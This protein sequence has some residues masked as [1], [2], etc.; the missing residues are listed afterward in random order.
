[1]WIPA[2][3]VGFRNS[4][5]VTASRVPMGKD[6]A[7]VAVLGRSYRSVAFTLRR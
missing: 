7:G 5:A 6:F 4:Q 1:L 3:R 2:S